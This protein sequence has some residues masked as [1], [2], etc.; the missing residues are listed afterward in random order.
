MAVMLVTTE[1]IVLSHR[2]RVSEIL[3]DPRV[4]EAAERARSQ[5]KGQNGSVPGGAGQGNTASSNG[6]SSNGASAQAGTSNV[7]VVSSNSHLSLF[8]S[9]LAV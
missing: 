4:R 5:N 8:A 3:A 1:P 9:C 7:R 6:S 2:E